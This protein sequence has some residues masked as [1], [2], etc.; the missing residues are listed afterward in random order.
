MNK[1]SRGNYAWDI[2]ALNS[3]MMTY[4]GYGAKNNQYAIW[5][6]NTLL[7]MP[8]KIVTRVEKEVDNPPDLIAA[9]DMGDHENGR[10]V[11]LEEK[12]QNLVEI[13]PLL[14]LDSPFLLRLIHL[15]QNSIPD[16]I[17]VRVL[18]RGTILIIF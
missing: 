6:V 15:K 9:V 16:N 11:D 8:G 10:D 7:P 17:Q 1:F 13:K 14:G 12:P 18:S 2:G 3:N 5:E 4:S